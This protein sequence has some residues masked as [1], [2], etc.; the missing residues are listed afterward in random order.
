MNL[1]KKTIR[2]I[3]HRYSGFSRVIT[4]VMH[5]GG[6]EKRDAFFPAPKPVA[7][8]NIALFLLGLMISAMQMK[9]SFRWLGGPLDF[10]AKKEEE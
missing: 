8:H 1:L 6:S 4:A 10:V 2:C 5:Y 7:N 9:N 3:P